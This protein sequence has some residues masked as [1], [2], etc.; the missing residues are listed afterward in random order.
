MEQE[1][2]FILGKLFMGII[3][4]HYFYTTYSHLPRLLATDIDWSNSC[5]WNLYPR[6]GPLSN[7]LLARFLPIWM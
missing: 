5:N 6:N 4:I 7:L 2:R 1:Q 3:S